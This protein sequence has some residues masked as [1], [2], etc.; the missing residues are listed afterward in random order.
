MQI[1][2][3]HPYYQSL[4]NDFSLYN[5]D[6]LELMKKIPSETF[7]L[8]FADPPYFLSNGGVTCSAGKMVSVNKGAWDSKNDLQEIFDFNFQWLQECK[9]L[10]KPNGT[11][12]VSGTYHNIY[13]I[14]SILQQL[15]YKILNNIIW[16]KRN[17]P[18]NLS[19][20]FFTHSTETILWAKKNSKAK[21]FFNYKVM[22]ELNNNKQM[23]DVWTIPGVSKREKEFGKHPTQ[24]PI[25][26]LERIIL[27]STK[28]NDLVLDPFNG[29]GTTGIAC[30]ENNRKFVGI[31]IDKD[32][33]EVSIK[34]SRNVQKKML[35]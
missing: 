17:P 23:K 21:H 2:P 31:D 19:C 27:A 32:Y 22:K 29:S 11:L 30:L 24:K 4:E 9:R 1:I 10:L 34:R 33:L 7:D 3:A 35:I 18:P 20:R 25:K 26:L 6:S 8:V 5:E 28:E 12:W 13:I 16:Q 15:E 14:G